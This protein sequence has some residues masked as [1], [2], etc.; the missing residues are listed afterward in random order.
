M[1]RLYDWF[2]CRNNRII[3]DVGGKVEMEISIILDNKVV[4]EKE[5][6]IYKKT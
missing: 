1:C 4:Y 6:K 5:F 2:A 3:Y